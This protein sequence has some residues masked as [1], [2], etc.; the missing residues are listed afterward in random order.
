MRIFA[1]RGC[2]SAS[3]TARGRALVVAV[4]AAIS[5][6]AAAQTA[7]AQY[8]WTGSASGNFSDTTQ[9]L[10]GNAPGATGSASTTLAFTPTYQLAASTATLTPAATFLLNNLTF[11]SFSNPAFTVTGAS[12]TFFR[13]S[14]NGPTLPTITLSGNNISNNVIGAITTGGVQLDADTTINGSGMGNLTI[15]SVISESAPGKKLTITGSPVT[16][17]SRVVNLNAANT[18]TGGLFLDGGNVQ[19][20]NAGGL[21]TAANTFT[22]TPNGGTIGVTGTS[23]VGNIVLNGKL[24]VVAGSMS[25]GTVAAPTN[26]SGAG[27]LVLH[28]NTTTLTSSVAQSL[29]TGTVTMDKFD[30]PVSTAAAGTL[31]LNNAGGSMQGVTTYNIRNGGTLNANDNVG[32][33]AQNTDRINNNATVNLASGNL[34]VLGAFSTSGGGT[35]YSAA[36]DTNEVIGAVNG[37]GYSTIRALL[38]TGTSTKKTTVSVASISRVDRGTFLFGGQNLGA[39]TNSSGNI[40]ITSAPTA[41]LIGG[42]GGVASQTISILPY[43][44]AEK[45]NSSSFAGGTFVTLNGNS[46]RALD[47]ATE[48]APNLTS[49]SATNARATGTMAGGG[50]TVNSLLLDGTSSATVPVVVSGPG[51]L[52][53]NSGAILSNTGTSTGNTIQS[54]IAFP[55][56]IEGHI[57]S[58]QTAGGSTGLTISGQLSGNN[59]LTKS[60]NSPVFLSNPNN[61]SSL[62]GTLTF[63]A[64]TIE[65][66]NQ[67]AL[68]GTGQIVANG[69]TVGSGVT[70]SNAATLSYSAPGVMNLN[71]DIAV[72]SGFFTVRAGGVLQSTSVLGSVINLNGVISGSGSLNYQAQSAAVGFTPCEIWVNGINNTYTGFSRIAGGS[73]VHIAGDGSLGNG[74][75]IDLDGGMLVLEGDLNTN[76]HVNVATTSTIDTNGH[77]A[78]LN[79]TFTGIGVANLYA[80]SATAALSKNGLGTLTLTSTNNMFAAPL[81]VNQGTL[82]VN[83]SLGASTSAAVTVGNVTTPTVFATLGGSGVIPRNITVNSG[84]TLS[85]GNSAGILTEFGNLNL[86]SGSNF[87]VD[88][89]GAF[90]GTGFD[91]MVVNGTVA[92]TGSN[93]NFNL[94]FNPFGHDYFILTNDGTDA[95]TGT[96][97]GM[98][99]LST[100][101]LGTLGAT[102]VTATISYF[103]DSA[104]NAVT[105]GNDV[106]LYNIVPAP[107][108]AALLGLAGLIAARRRRA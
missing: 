46:V 41:D 50:N 62:T 10:S 42:G 17:L 63:N 68:P 53:V 94:G 43:A 7:H 29:Y 108:S 99:N 104:T 102:T 49:G 83:G 23:T 79:G 3:E 16:G 25:L 75:G 20:G 93:L 24:R 15:S 12:G 26:L 40:T 89:N 4:G 107:G 84:S 91:Q 100:V 96:F 78:T 8:V 82:L 87:L 54:D 71:R 86:V 90:V 58:T 5:L 105:G 55:N 51:A 72:N 38:G 65:V 97:S 81:N 36:V 61:S 106:V 88:L 18:F 76:R 32:T 92:L 77:N 85:P 13:M 22:V 21:G 48:Y 47:L 70:G 60:G 6:G 37:A 98:A 2:D 52:T 9:W 44:I 39:G 67:G 59:G 31:T 69:A 33:V 11:N 66:S 35:N 27:E 28:G 1:N 101:V 45:S 19:M 56:L 57:F 80:Q 14:A 30:L 64:G 73:K 74:G 95:I 34:V 103:G